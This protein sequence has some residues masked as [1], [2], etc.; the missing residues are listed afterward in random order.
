MRKRCFDW[1]GS[2]CTS[3]GRNAWRISGNSTAPPPAAFS[4][5]GVMSDLAEV[6]RFAV[7]PVRRTE[8]ANIDVALARGELVE[9]PRLRV[10][11]ARLVAR[12]EGAVVDL[13]SHQKR[14]ANEVGQVTRDALD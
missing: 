6:D 1:S 2:P 5:D 14:L 7:V 9:R 12:R 8:P 4:L 11:V 3:V 13:L 10:V